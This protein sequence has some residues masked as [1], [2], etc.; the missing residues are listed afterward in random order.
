MNGGDERPGLTRTISGWRPYFYGRSCRILALGP[1]HPLEVSCRRKPQTFCDTRW[2][3]RSDVADGKE[4]DMNLKAVIGVVAVVVSGAG[5]AYAQGA[6]DFSKTA[7]PE[8]VGAMAK[9]LQAT[10][11]QAEGAAG[12][13]LGTAKQKLQPADWSKVSS[14]IPG[15]DGLLKA[16]PMMA[17]A[18]GTSGGA[19]GAAAAAVGAG[20]GSLGSVAAAFSKLGL[21]PELVSKAIP[22][23]TQYVTKSGGAGVGSLLAGV[24]K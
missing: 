5:L 3:P 17:A 19:A 15:V 6:A 11:Q 21:K 2:A 13:L 7:N 18:T 20:A 16:A 9:E 24:L 14:A 8:L 12:A 1:E 10:P 22:V 23:L 4:P